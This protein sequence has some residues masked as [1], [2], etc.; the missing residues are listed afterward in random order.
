VL[1]E[2]EVGIKPRLERTETEFLESPPLAL[3]KGGI[4]KVGERRATPECQRLT[5]LVS[6]AR[7]ILIASLRHKLVEALKV[8]LSRVEIDQ[9][10]G[11]L[12][13]DQIASERRSKLRHVCLEGVR[14]TLGR[15][16][17]PERLDEAVA[18]HNPVRV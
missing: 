10:A 11:R 7:R 9:V 8:K 18:G 2:R 17:V 16:V 3:E 1:T 12:G 4:R 6:R 15:R 13:N 14:G 5:E